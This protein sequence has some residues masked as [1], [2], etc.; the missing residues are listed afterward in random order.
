MVKRAAFCRSTYIL[1]MKVLWTQGFPI[2]SLKDR[3]EFSKMSCK[4]YRMNHVKAVVLVFNIS[5]E[6]NTS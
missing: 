2:V 1:K 5:Y 6:Y 4:T 3:G